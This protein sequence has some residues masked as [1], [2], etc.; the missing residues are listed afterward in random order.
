V[1]FVNSLTL[2]QK[3]H[4]PR[5]EENSDINFPQEFSV[6]LARNYTDEYRPN[7]I[8]HLGRMSD[9]RRAK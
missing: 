9:K 5:K 1:N 2:I 6:Q 7:W 3:Y 4:E 8:L